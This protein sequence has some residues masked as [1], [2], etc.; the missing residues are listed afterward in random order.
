M[1]Y[2]G[3]PNIARMKWISLI[4]L[5]FLSSFATAQETDETTI[6]AKLYIPA[7]ALKGIT[8]DQKLVIQFVAEKPDEKFE[9]GAI[10]AKRVSE[11]IYSFYIKPW[12]YFRLVFVIGDYSY[13]MMCINN[14]ERTASDDYYFNILLEKQKFNP[15]DLKFI[16]P[17]IRDEEE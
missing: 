1:L 8:A 12:M 15:E 10:Q 9:T 13:N 11:N 17:C 3:Q 14:R 4:S 5:I 16:A 7:N 6:E 2:I